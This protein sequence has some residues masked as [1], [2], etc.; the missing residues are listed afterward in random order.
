MRKL[1]LKGVVFILLGGVFLVPL[2]L[3]LR[4]IHR[5]SAASE[6][7][8][9]PATVSVV[10]AGDSHGETGVNP[11]LIPGA[12][13]ISHS[14]ENYFFTYYK[15]K[16]FLER[17]H[18]VKKVLLGCSWHNFPLKYQDAFLY[19]EIPEHIAEYFP[20][21]DGEG[22]GVI[23]SWES[24]YTIPWMKY[25]LGAPF[26]L[27]LDQ[28][29]QKSLLGK[30]VTGQEYGFLGGYRGS[31]QSKVTKEA[32]A[33]KVARYFYD[34]A[35]PSAPS[36]YMV[37]YLEKILDLCAKRDVQVYLVNFPVHPE[38]RKQVPAQTV[39]AYE[40]VKRRVSS[41]YPRARWLDFADLELPRGYYL[42]GDHLNE[43][44]AAALAGPLKVAVADR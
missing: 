29:F 33:R 32:V 41:K 18:Q 30:R 38:Y 3:H 14:A 34:G 13:N 40:E 43:K 39:A 27:Y 23:Q 44:G 36:P 9:L 16:L 10:V 21:L 24:S 6:Y 26:N 17:N 42:D 2:C 8:R 4:S 19:G 20:V 22:R 5:V 35:T 11:S 37:R 15:L 12:A 28:V 25:M 1:A 7:T 31:A